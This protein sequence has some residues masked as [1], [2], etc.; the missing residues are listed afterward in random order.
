MS[1]SHGFYQLVMKSK[2]AFKDINKT[3]FLEFLYLRMLNYAMHV[4][5]YFYYLCKYDYFF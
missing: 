4:L 5:F 3:I 2:N 1:S